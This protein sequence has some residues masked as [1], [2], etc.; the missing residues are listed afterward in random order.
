MSN[1]EIPITIPTTE[2][3]IEDYIL[4]IIAEENN[5]FEYSTTNIKL[6]IKNKNIITVDDSINESSSNTH[7]LQDAINLID[8]NGTVNIITDINN[9]NINITKSITINGNGNNMNNTTITNNSSEVLVKNINFDT[10]YIINN[11]E[12]LIDECTFTHSTESAIITNDKITIYNC[13]FDN[14]CADYGACIYIKNQNS[15]TIIDKCIFTNNNAQYYGGCIYS[16]KGNDIE[17]TNCEFYNQ[18]HATLN[19]TSISI[20]GN[21]YISHNVFYNN[22]GANEIYLMNGNIEMDTNIF[23]AN[24]DAVN[25]LYGYIDADFNYW[26]YNDEDDI[27]NIISSQNININNYLISRCQTTRKDNN[28]FYAIGLIDQYTNRL[29]FEVD[30]ALER[31]IINIDAID[32]N[33]PVRVGN[34]QSSLNKK[35]IVIHNNCEMIIGKAIIDVVL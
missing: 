6:N 29:Q 16:N 28:S 24:I 20:Y 22:I 23:D 17:I 8:N 7:T 10:S 34:V 4:Q 3:N 35:D 21:A 11:K 27:N 33:L 19:G 15:S 13:I 5:I 14:N 9:E 30:N 1:Y 31:E 2:Q 26:G 32:A 18:N 25:I 12:L